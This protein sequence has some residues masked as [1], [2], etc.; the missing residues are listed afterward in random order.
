MPT[1][2]FQ[3]RGRRRRTTARS[4]GAAAGPAPSNAQRTAPA[5]D[6]D[7][8]VLVRIDRGGVNICEAELRYQLDSKDRHPLARRAELLDLLAELEDRGLIESALHFRLTDRG[9]AELPGDH[10]PPPRAGDLRG[11]PWTVEL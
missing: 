3:E 4:R 2:Q 5:N 7:R 11:I 1:A 6:E 9:R 10:E 8:Q